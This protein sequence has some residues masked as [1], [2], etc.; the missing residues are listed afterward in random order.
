MTLRRK[1]RPRRLNTIET[2]VVIYA[3]NRSFDNLYGSFPGANGLQN[4]TPANSR[5]VDRDGSRLKE[6]PP[7]WEWADGKGVTPPVTEAQTGHL[8]NKPFA[9]RRSKGFNTSLGVTT[10]DLWHLFYQNQMQIDGGKNDRFAA[11]AD[12]GE[13]VFFGDAPQRQLRAIV[14]A[15]HQPTGI[16]ESREAIVLAAVD[17]HLV[18]IEQV[19]EIARGDAERRIEAFGSSMPNGLFGRCPV[20]ASV[21]GGVMPLPVSPPQTGGNSLSREPS[22]SNCRELAGVTFC[23]PLAPGN[24]PYRLSKLRFS[25]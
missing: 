22:R 9:H 17:L 2:V 13:H 6:L 15:H 3:E 10:R 16:G 19:P 4:V 8:P 11:F 21:T 12:S 7:V 18:L 23:K 25:A 5:Q 24:E 1:T 20:W 14:V